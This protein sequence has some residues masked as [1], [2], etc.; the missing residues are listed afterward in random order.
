MSNRA[1]AAIANAA[2]IDAGII[3]PED[4]KHVIDKNKLRSA[5]EKYR[6]ERKVE[7]ATD[8]EERQGHAYYFD[9]FTLCRRR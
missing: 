5:I 8:L 2:L 7:D 3:T 1:G 9:Y 6:N 4:Q